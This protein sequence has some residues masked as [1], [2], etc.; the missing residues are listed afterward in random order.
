ML[1]SCKDIFKS[2]LGNSVEEEISL[3]P[4]SNNTI[5]QDFTQ[6]ADIPIY[7]HQIVPSLSPLN[8]PTQYIRCHA[9]IIII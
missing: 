4:L 9:F 8:L 6:F 3:V 2:V 7:P 1:L 5:S